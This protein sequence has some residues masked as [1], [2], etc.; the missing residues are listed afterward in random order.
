MPTIQ[1]QDGLRENPLRPADWRWK[2]AT[3]IVTNNVRIVRKRD[4][5][6]VF[7]AVKFLRALQ[8]AG[9]ELGCRRL[10]KKFPDIVLA[11]KC[12]DGDHMLR[13][14]L[15]CRIL[16]RQPPE[17]IAEYLEVPVAMVDAFRLYFFD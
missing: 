2:R 5:E 15:E 10:M 9:A 6:F 17:L 1:I 4:D 14:E 8:R 13:L 12:H 7:R 16:G 11:L 3:W